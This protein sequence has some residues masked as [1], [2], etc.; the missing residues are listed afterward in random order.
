MC[1]WMATTVM[2]AA[3]MFGPRVTGTVRLIPVVIGLRIAGF[4]AMGSGSWLK[5]IGGRL[6]LTGGAM[7]RGPSGPLFCVLRSSRNGLEAY[8]ERELDAGT[9]AVEKVVAVADVVNVDIVG[10]VPVWI[11]IFRPGVQQ[12]EP[13]AVILEA[14]QAADEDHG[15]FADAEE[16]VVAEVEAESIIGNAIAV[17]ATALGPSLM[18]GLKG[19]RAGL[20]EARLDL[21]LM[22]GNAARVDAAVGGTVDLDAAVV[23]AAI[24]LL[25]N[26]RAGG[27]G[28]SGLC[29]AFFLFVLG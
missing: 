24:G 22:L 29:L 10:G 8:G 7:K 17:V 14:G 20:H 9:V 26:D 19:G 21:T 11:P 27:G 18:L 2:T 13:E 4:I 25:V 3:T 6:N 5:G 23:S 28:V 16:V 12:R 15:Q 1:G